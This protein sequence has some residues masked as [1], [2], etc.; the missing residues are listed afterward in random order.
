[1]SEKT[2][3]IGYR[4]D[5]I[6]RAFARSIREALTHRGYDVFLDVDNL[7]AG[8]WAEQ[9]SREVPRRA[10]YLL[11]LTPGALD[12]CTALGDWVRREYELAVQHDR[13]I[14]PVA[15]ESVD[16][17]K[18][19]EAAPDAMRG[20]FAHQ[21]A[22]I[23]HA[24]FNADIENLAR[25]YVS[26]EKAP[27]PPPIA[28]A[29]PREHDRPKPIHLPYRSIGTL[30]KGRDDALAD[31]RRSLTRG[32][33]ASATSATAITGLALHGLGGVGKTRLAVEYAWRHAEHHSALLFVG[34]E[35]P[36][37]LERHLAALCDPMI[38][39]LP[40]KNEREDAVRIAAVLRWLREHPGW[41]L[42]LDNI[43]SRDAGEAVERLLPRLHGGYVLVT[44][45]LSEWSPQVAA[46]VLHMMSFDDAIDFLLSRTDAHRRKASN[47]PLQARTLATELDRLALAL[48]QAG[49]YIAHYGIG[50]TEYLSTWQSNRDR[51]LAWIDERAMQYSRSVAV[52]WLTSFDRLTKPARDLLQ[53]LAWLAPEPIPE[54]LLVTFSEKHTVDEV[55]EDPA[56]P[57]HH[58]SADA[59]VELVAHS[60][61][62]RDV[63]A[64]TFMIH[65]LVQDV[66][67]RRQSDV[68]PP[69]GLRE[70]VEWID[71]AFTGHPLDPQSRPMLEQ[72]L[73]HAISVSASAA[74]MSIAEPSTRLMSAAA[75]VLYE[76]ATSP[77]AIQARTRVR[78]IAAQGF[79]L[80][81]PDALSHLK[82]ISEVLPFTQRISEAE[83]L[84]R[85]ALEL[86]EKT[87]GKS[88]PKVAAYLGNLALFLQTTARNAEAESLY[89]RA[90]EIDEMDIRSDKHEVA[91]RLFLFSLLLRNAGRFADA[92]PFCRR[93]LT[94]QEVFLGPEDIAST[95][96]RMDIG[97][98]IDSGSVATTLYVLAGL[99]RDTEQFDEAVLLYRK[100]LDLSEKL[101]GLESVILCD[102]LF[103]LADILVRMKRG[104]EAEPLYRRALSIQEN[105]RVLDREMFAATYNNLATLLAEDNRLV[106]AQSFGRRAVE[107]SLELEKQGGEPHPQTSAVIENYRRIL[108]VLNRTKPE[109][110]RA[111]LDQ[112]INLLARGG[113]DPEA[114]QA[115]RGLASS[116]ANGSPPIPDTSPL[117]P[118]RRRRWLARLLGH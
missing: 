16:L 56:A 71:R 45:R 62:A 50:F 111:I 6:G 44:G 98:F 64:H 49:A 28:Q 104:S 55:T 86:T 85:R 108:I 80:D 92:I 5:A 8:K 27:K 33:S 66:G 43:D 9:L 18:A 47:D 46:M 77:E 35:T 89:R 2:V 70:A 15:E 103:G 101:Y 31:L 21:I 84:H 112:E 14:V 116:A 13:N 114:I 29:S 95:A 59:L 94:I 97:L 78:E 99:L 51:A 38:L 54:A 53:R 91:R 42:I 41:L 75:S 32:S 67:R 48:E 34:A 81:H 115:L 63:A 107:L 25:R 76:Q 3:F 68:T 30:L 23:R 1:M 73:P 90:L 20:V 52:T 12:R 109:A 19:R 36:G 83:A 118:P 72:L 102:V 26:P 17:G 39:D 37:D 74:S 110:V 65:R 93:A 87:Y 117:P 79:R 61:V 57:L 69:A 58:E 24:T 88:H 106:E 40:E 7:D 4:R 10:H 96:P 11:M 113:A 82:I 100:A 105:G 22:T 60:L